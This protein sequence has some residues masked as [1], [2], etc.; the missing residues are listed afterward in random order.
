M[1]NSP[2]PNR[3]R[4]LTADELIAIGVALAGIGTVFFWGLGQKYQPM[5]QG[6]MSSLNNDNSNRQVGVLGN[7]NIYL[8]RERRTIADSARVETPPSAPSAPPATFVPPIVK[9]VEV[10]VVETPKTVVPQVVTPTKVS[11]V[12]AFTDVPKQF[13]A[14]NYINEL[15]KR[16]ILDDFGDGKFDPSKEITRG[17]YAKMLDRAFADKPVMMATSK[18]A[19]IPTDYSRKEAIDKSVQLGFMT[20]YSPTKFFP[21]QPI[22]R[23]QLQISLAKGL[24]LAVPTS[25]GQVLSKFKDADRMPKFAKDK[26]AAAIDAGLIIKD[27]DTNLLKPV[28]NATRADAAALIYQ[29]LV[30][31]GKIQP[32]K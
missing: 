27:K 12:P 6:A 26:M 16:G 29:S 30:K 23:Y 14:E 3:R 31:E 7:R 18:F 28:A 32:Q 2:N 24:K 4:R 21:N 17:E 9:T 25:T 11:V 19:D 10:P 1:T 22:P 20:G 5:F 13:W 8:N 15:Q